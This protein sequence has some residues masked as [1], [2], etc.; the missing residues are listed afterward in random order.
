MM[1][2]LVLDLAAD[3]IPVA[4]T[5]R[6]LGFSTQAFYQWKK[7]PVTDRDW[8]DAHLINAA[9]DIHQDDPEFGYRSSPTNSPGPASPP[10][11][12]GSTAYAPCNG[13]G[14]ST[15]KSAAHTAPGGRRC[16]TISS[17]GGSPPSNAISYG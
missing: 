6:V 4:V 16:T 17:N 10:A 11:A 12:N 13:C 3:R 15:R 7:H 5:C 2:P 1:F 14:R 9:I 8:A